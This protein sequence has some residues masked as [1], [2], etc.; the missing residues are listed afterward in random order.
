MMIKQVTSKKDCYLGPG[1]SADI[2]A[3]SGMPMLIA[4]PPKG[5]YNAN[6]A[7]LILNVTAPY[8][9]GEDYPGIEFSITQKYGKKAAVPIVKGI[10]TCESEEPDSPGRKPITLVKVVELEMNQSTVY[11]HWQSIRNSECVIDGGGTATL[12][13]ILAE[14][15]YPDMPEPW[16]YV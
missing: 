5:K 3:D 11:A 16:E 4:L 2:P 13:A 12:T 8:A 10:V 9:R 15:I 6:A 14:G 1:G 7:V